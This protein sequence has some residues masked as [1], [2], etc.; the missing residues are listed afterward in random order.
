MS[1]DTFSIMQRPG[2]SR[3]DVVIS[4]VWWHFC[5]VRIAKFLLLAPSNPTSVWPPWSTHQAACLWRHKMYLAPPKWESER[6]TNGPPGFPLVATLLQPQPPSWQFYRIKPSDFGLNHTLADLNST[7]NYINRADYWAYAS[8][9]AINLGVKNVNSGVS[10][11][12]E[13]TVYVV[14]PRCGIFK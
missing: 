12:G 1:L 10:S 4:V 14:A 3:R 7:V 2:K 6:P 13:C 5:V 9:M 11:S 8:I